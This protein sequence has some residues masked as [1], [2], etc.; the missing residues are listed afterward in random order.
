MNELLKRAI[1][2]TV[3][4]GLIVATTSYSFAFTSILMGFFVYICCTELGKI[5]GMTE[6]QISAQQIIA[7]LSYYLLIT[8]V[9]IS[10][11]DFYYVPFAIVS[12]TLIA[13]TAYKEAEQ[14]FSIIYITIPLALLSFIGISDYRYIN[15]EWQYNE[16]FNTDPILMIFILIW[17]YDTFAYLCGKFMGK[18]LLAPKISPKKTWEGVF[19]GLSFT[20]LCAILLQYLFDIDLGILIPSAFIVVIFGTLGDLFESFLKRRANVKDSGNLLPGHGG[21]LDRLDG[22]LLAIPTVVAYI[23]IYQNI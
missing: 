12:G 16:H 19:G 18:H 14:V 22:A 5:L 9:F 8:P 17:C 23:F 21:L 2:G 6:K 1:V 11:G 10:L 3:Y 13:L 20:F 4:V 15:G 7:V